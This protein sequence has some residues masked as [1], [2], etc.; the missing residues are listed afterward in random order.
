MEVEQSVGE[1]FESTPVKA[2]PAP[3]SS[4]NRSSV[5]RGEHRIVLVDG[6]SS[7]LQDVGI[8]FRFYDDADEKDLEPNFVGCVA[9]L[10]IGAYRLSKQAHRPTDF[11]NLGLPTRLMSS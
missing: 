4:Q 8:E 5:V 2:R 6:E 9:C 7:L 11:V 3:R 10:R 1:R